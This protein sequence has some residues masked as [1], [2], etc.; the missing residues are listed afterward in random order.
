MYSPHQLNKQ[1]Q[2]VR[3]R[4]PGTSIRSPRYAA[5]GKNPENLV[6]QTQ[7]LAWFLRRLRR[8]TQPSFLGSG[9]RD[10]VAHTCAKR[11]A[12]RPPRGAVFFDLPALPGGREEVLWSGS[13]GMDAGRAAMGHGW[14]VAAGPRSRT[15]ARE[16]ERSEGRTMGR[17]PFGSFWVLPKGTRRKVETIVSVRH[18]CRICTQRIS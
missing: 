1:D 15:G 6:Y 11:P 5:I 14:P 2:A 16:P 9:Y 12:G 10:C 4:K 17:G 3:N 8:R 13:T 7:R 18:K